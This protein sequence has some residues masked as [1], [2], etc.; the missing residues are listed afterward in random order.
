MDH[1][2]SPTACF[3]SITNI[4]KGKGSWVKSTSSLLE[5]PK[6]PKPTPQRPPCSFRLLACGLGQV[7]THLWKQFHYVYLQAAL[8]AERDKTQIFTLAP[9]NSDDSIQDMNLSP[10]TGQVTKPGSTCILDK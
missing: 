8:W 5:M 10:N 7:P 3:L 2:G 4:S 1:Q 9:A 6:A